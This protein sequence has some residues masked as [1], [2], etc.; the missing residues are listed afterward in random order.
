MSIKQEWQRKWREALGE[1]T[2]SMPDIREDYA[3]HFDIWN[4][5]DEKLQECFSI[6]PNGDRLFKRV[7]EVRKTHPQ[8][9]EIDDEKLLGKLDQLNEDIEAVLR[10]FGD[11]ELIQLNGEKST[12]K[13]RS[14]Y[15][16]SESQRHEILKNSDSP[17]VHLDDELCEIIEKHCGEEG[18]EAFF[19]L[20]EPLYQLSGCYYTV[21]HWIAW[22]MVE[23]EYDS[24]PYQAAFDLYKIKAQARWSSDEQFIYI[25]S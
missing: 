16:G 14:V 23:A 6:F 3:L 25:A 22:A 19:F 8:T 7:N 12:A 13:K 10:D 24:D 20:S 4:V 1:P 15:R 9:T 2:D 18:Y 11:E 17:T 5:S 21:S